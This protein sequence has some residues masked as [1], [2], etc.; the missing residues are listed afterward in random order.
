MQLKL[1]NSSLSILLI[2]FLHWREVIDPPLKFIWKV[3]LFRPSILD[4]L[5]GRPLATLLSLCTRKNQCTLIFLFAKWATVETYR[6]GHQF[7]LIRPAD[8]CTIYAVK[9][10][11]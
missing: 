10:E 11:N 9:S 2:T 6:F 5:R 4:V 1:W 3:S 7:L 8:L